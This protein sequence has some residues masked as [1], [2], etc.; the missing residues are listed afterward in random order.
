MAF[1]EAVSVTSWQVVGKRPDA[2]LKWLHK[3]VLRVGRNSA[4]LRMIQALVLASKGRIAAPAIYDIVPRPEMTRFL[5]AGGDGA[6][7]RILHVYVGS[8]LHTQPAPAS[9]HHAAS[10]LIVEYH[11]PISC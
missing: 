7:V 6:S 5:R 8:R 2:R 10:A 9:S 4:P 1:A 3:A 11:G